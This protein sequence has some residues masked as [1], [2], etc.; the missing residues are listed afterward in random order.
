MAI[1][2]L[3]KL[4]VVVYR[5]TKTFDLLEDLRR[6]D[7]TKQD[8]ITLGTRAKSLFEQ[9]HAI[10]R[11]DLPESEGR[12][13]FESV[14][15][16]RADDDDQLFEVINSHNAFQDAELDPHVNFAKYIWSEL[17][18]TE[19]GRLIWRSSFDLLICRCGRTCYD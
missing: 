12:T 5:G 16:F 13:G 10:L 6:A 15:S 14:F 1:Y 7:P 2:S 3:K 9:L 17:Y 11:Q 8:M 4:S 19:S 18:A